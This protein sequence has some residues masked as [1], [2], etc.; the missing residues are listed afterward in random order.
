MVKVYNMSVTKFAHFHLQELKYHSSAIKFFYQ[1][2]L[3]NMYVFDRPTQRFL[4][5][6]PIEVLFLFPE[7][8]VR[9]RYRYFRFCILL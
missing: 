5:E 1:A 8:W 6:F 2:T 3:K 9:F 7:F 4:F